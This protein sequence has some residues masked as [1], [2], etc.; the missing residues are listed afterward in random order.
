M[1]AIN[2]IVIIAILW[3][4][5][6]VI[7]GVIV[8][9]SRRKYKH[10]YRTER[11]QSHFAEARNELMRLALSGEANVN[12]E[13]FKHFY[14]FNTALMRRSDQYPELSSAMTHKFLCERGAITD[15]VLD[16][17]SK[18]WTPAFRHVVVRT[19]NAMDYIVL[20]YSWAIR[21]MFRFERRKQPHLTPIRMLRHFAETIEKEEPI[22]EIRRTQKA[23]YR[24][25]GA[26]A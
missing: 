6:E 9:R 1:N 22:A 14:Y 13:S 15:S 10:E 19:A 26:T 3:A 5:R 21:L 24:M 8:M 23:M 7:I 12:S 20:D 17:E 4:V 25:A 2:F 16:Q 18:H 11:T